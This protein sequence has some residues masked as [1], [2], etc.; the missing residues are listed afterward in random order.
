[1]DF[2]VVQI[3][4]FVDSHQP[5]FVS[6]EFVDAAGGSHTI[7]DKV[8]VLSR[9]D[10][11]ESSAYPKPGIVGCEVMA[12]WRDDEG[13]DL[14]RISTEK[15]WNIESTEGVSQFVVRADQLEAT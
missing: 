9:E 2:L 8:P 13:R 7:I 14:V 6:C 12:R 5:G 4:R 11:D 1:M 3:V 10:L 15:P